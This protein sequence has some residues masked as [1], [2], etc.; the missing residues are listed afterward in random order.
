METFHFGI[1]ES[2]DKEHRII[3]GKGRIGITQK[4]GMGGQFI[5]EVKGG[6]FMV[7]LRRGIF[8]QG[9]YKVCRLDYLIKKTLQ[10]CPKTLYPP[11]YSQGARKI[12]FKFKLLL[13]PNVTCP[14]P[15][16]WRV[17]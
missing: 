11:C 6:Q 12:T 14:A 2:C 5:I 4:Y 1:K 7:K 3:W 15:C 8:I 16:S 10:F 13:N 17:C 9:G